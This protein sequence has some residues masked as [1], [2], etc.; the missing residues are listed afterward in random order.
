MKQRTSLSGTTKKLIFI[1][2]TLVVVAILLL[3]GNV[4]V[5]F[6]EYAM[7]VSATMTS[8]AVISYDDIKGVLWDTDLTVGRRVF[9]LGSLR[10]RTGDFKNEKYG[11]YQLYAYAGA[12]AYVVVQRKDGEIIVFA[13]A[14]TA[15]TKAAYETLMEHVNLAS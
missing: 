14:D 4:N 8:G 10:L 13:L 1:G 6:D 9:G 7:Q 12:D 15:T 2:F 5:Q 3:I 11:D